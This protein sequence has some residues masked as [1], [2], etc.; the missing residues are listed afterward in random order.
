MLFA[1]GLRAALGVQKMRVIAQLVLLLLLAGC[2]GSEISSEIYRQAATGDGRLDL[3]EVGGPNW[4]RVC[5]LGPY[6]TNAAAEKAL[7]F[8]WDV[9]ARTDIESS[10]GINVLVL[11]AKREVVSYTE[12]SRRQDFLK[13][14][15]QCFPRSQAIFIKRDGSYVLS[16]AQQTLARD[17]RNARA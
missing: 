8:A 11:V 6:T 5:F 14:S 9:E 16:I 17:V 12:H 10:D 15:G 2:S 7:G 3:T 13:L 1:R 4:D